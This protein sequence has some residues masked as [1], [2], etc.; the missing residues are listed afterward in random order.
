MSD[1]KL[2]DAFNRLAFKHF[3]A[4]RRTVRVADQVLQ[5]TK[6]DL[7]DSWTVAFRAGRK[8]AL[9]EVEN[10]GRRGGS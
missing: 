7:W 10:L 3:W 1:E 8:A 5:V 4:R 9:R 2:A 6:E